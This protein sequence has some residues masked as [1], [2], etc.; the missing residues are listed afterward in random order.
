MDK[1]TLSFGV[2]GILS[3]AMGLYQL[4]LSRKR[5]AFFFLCCFLGVAAGYWRDEYHPGIVAPIQRTPVSL[6]PDSTPSPTTHVTRSKPVP[7]TL[8]VVNSIRST[9]P[10][11]TFHAVEVASAA[12]H[13]DS[14]LINIM[15]NDEIATGDTPASAEI[16]AQSIRELLERYNFDLIKALAAYRAGVN[17]ID[18]Y[19]GIPQDIKPYVSRIVR[20]YN[21]K[22][23]HQDPRQRAAQ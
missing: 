4:S 18:E 3:F 14:D 15:I 2:I 11:L 1:L 9:N 6:L 19:G 12:Y 5:A 23:E 22:K 20:E 8:E 10:A 16:V 7:M 21:I 13:M 17:R